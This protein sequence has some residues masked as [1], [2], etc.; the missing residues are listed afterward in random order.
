MKKTHTSIMYALPWRVSKHGVNPDVFQDG[1]FIL[2]ASKGTAEY[3][4]NS[5]F[6]LKP[7]ERKLLKRVRVTIEPVNA[8]KSSKRKAKCVI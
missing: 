4:E 7:S 2:F 3:L 5:K 8:A 6:D 1:G